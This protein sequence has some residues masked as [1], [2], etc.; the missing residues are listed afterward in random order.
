MDMGDNKIITNRSNFLA[1]D[2][3]YP[4]L[5]LRNRPYLVTNTYIDKINGEYKVDYTFLPAG[6][7]CLAVGV[8]INYFQVLNLCGNQVTIAK[9]L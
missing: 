1:R 3:S 8:L 2:I 7:I 5:Q 4:L 9:V 6:K